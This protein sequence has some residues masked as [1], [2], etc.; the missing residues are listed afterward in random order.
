[1]HA[2][3]FHTANVIFKVTQGRTLTLMPFNTNLWSGISLSLQ[4]CAILYCIRDIVSYLPTH[5]LQVFSNAVFRT[6]LRLWF[7]CDVWRYIN[8]FLI[9]FDLQ[10]FEEVAWPRTHRIWGYSIMCTLVL[11]TLNMHTKFEVTTFTRSKYIME[12]PNLKRSC[13]LDYA[14]LGVGWFNGTFVNMK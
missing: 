7:A 3:R 2:T 4:L 1:M 14:H 9:W 11:A 12:P 5:R 13:D 8:V 10:K 6:A